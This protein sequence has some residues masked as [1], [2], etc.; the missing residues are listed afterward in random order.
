METRKPG[1]HQNPDGSM[2]IV[3][4]PREKE[5]AAPSVKPPESRVLAPD[6]RS[7]DAGRNVILPRTEEYQAAVKSIVGSGELDKG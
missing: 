4:P 5:A 7:I 3:M 6:G 1:I 2:E